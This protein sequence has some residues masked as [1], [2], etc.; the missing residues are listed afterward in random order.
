MGMDLFALRKSKVLLEKRD[1]EDNNDEYLER[2]CIDSYPIWS[3][4]RNSD[5]N[6]WP[7]C[8]QNFWW[9]IYDY[10]SAQYCAK[11]IRKYYPND[12]ELIRFACWLETFDRDIIFE[13]SI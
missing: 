3:S 10:D 11:K 2:E 5:V 9:H 6:T 8:L 4:W 13:L 12:K 7:K 1:D